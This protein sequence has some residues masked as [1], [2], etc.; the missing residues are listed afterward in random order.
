MDQDSRN[1][2]PRHPTIMGDGADTIMPM[3]E[4]DL[5]VMPAQTKIAEAISPAAPQPLGRAGA[6]GPCAPGL[7]P[8]AAGE[9]SA[10]AGELSAPAVPGPAATG[11]CGAM[12]TATP[13]SVPLLIGARPRI[14]G[15]GV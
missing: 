4:A 1:S 10:P 9:L 15:C 13:S 3:N 8:T 2:E 11:L 7:V 12:P 6:A 5:Q 14:A